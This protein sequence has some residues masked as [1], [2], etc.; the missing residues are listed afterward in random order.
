MA[1]IDR[2]KDGAERPRTGFGLAL[3]LLVALVMVVLMTEA[4]SNQPV[5]S[6]P[7]LS[8]VVDL[9]VGLHPNATR[10]VLEM[11]RQT[12]FRILSLD[13]P[14]R[15]IIDFIG[16]SCSPDLASRRGKGLIRSISEDRFTADTVRVVLALTRPVKVREATMLPEKDGHMPRF[17]LDL[18][19]TDRATFDRM[20]GQI[21]A[22]WPGSAFLAGR[23]FELAPASP[24]PHRPSPTTAERV[25]LASAG[26]PIVPPAPRSQPKPVRTPA[27]PSVP[28]VLPRPKPDYPRQ[29]VVLDPGH[30]GDD[31]GA[32]GVGGVHEKTITLAM[33]RELRDLLEA[34]GRYDVTLTRDRDVFIRLRDRVAIARK[35]NA[36]LFISLHADSIRLP[37][38]RGASVYTLSETASDREAQMLADKENRV[39][40]IGGIDIRGEDE[41]IASILIDLTQ[42][43]TMN[44]S[45][46]L[47][48]LLIRDLGKVTDLIP[49]PQRSAGFAVLT[50]A[51]VP[52]VLIEMGYLSSPDDAMALSRPD[53]RAKLAR[54]I[55]AAIDSY[56]QWLLASQGL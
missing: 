1:R 31:P 52:S 56:F 46:R 7:P 15:L 4:G 34:T 9:R 16:L 10:F 19:P 8:T 22:A 35:A 33:A 53:H 20:I 26:A 14:H 12:P 23:P 21:H 43:D 38:F 37:N 5:G 2:T 17:V 44:Q 47:A 29:I 45:R 24:Q 13:R 6:G 11:T 32:I 40:K 49:R 48:G 50:A 41:R 55:H 25:Q 27:A 18:E 51:D 54:A 28:H 30:G 39:D 36:D 3:P 42:R